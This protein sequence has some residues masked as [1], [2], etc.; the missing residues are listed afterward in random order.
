LGVKRSV[1]TDGRGVPIGLATAGANRHDQKLFHSTLDSIPVPRPRPTSKRPQHLCCDKGYDA[2]TLRREARRRRYRPHIK[3]RGEEQADKRHRR[4]RARRWVVE[5]VASWMNRFRRIL[6]RWEKKAD[7]Y[8]ALLHL[9]F[10][11]ITWKRT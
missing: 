3:P 5:R 6:I 4:G 1:L 10:T 8:E 11:Y 7:N 2:D 9:A